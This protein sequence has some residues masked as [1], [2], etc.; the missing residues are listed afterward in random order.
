MGEFAPP[1]PNAS[2]VDTPRVGKSHI[3]SNSYAGLT[4][5][6]ED[7]Q[8]PEAWEDYFD[9]LAPINDQLKDAK[10]W[11]ILEVYPTKHREQQRDV[12]GLLDKP[13]VIRFVLS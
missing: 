13:S 9:A 12:S 7:A 6:E 11:W 3:R 2:Q 5:L 10:G 4:G 8:L 1:L